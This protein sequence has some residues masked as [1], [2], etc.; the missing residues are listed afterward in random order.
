MAAKK[1]MAIFELSYVLTM[2]LSKVDI[3]SNFFALYINIWIVYPIPVQN[4]NIA[5]N[6]IIIGIIH[7]MPYIMLISE[8]RFKNCFIWFCIKKRQALKFI[9]NFEIE[10]KYT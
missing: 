3:N 9:H 2:V 10:K 8:R 7:L 4:A 1:P 5:L 6:I